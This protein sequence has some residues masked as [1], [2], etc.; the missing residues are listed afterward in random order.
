MHFGVAFF[1]AAAFALLCRRFPAL[2]RWSVPAGLLYGAAVWI[3]MY[4]VAIP[5]IPLVNSLYLTRFDRTMPKLRLRQLLIHLGCVGL[6]IALAAKRAARRSGEPRR[7]T[8]SRPVEA[9]GA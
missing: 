7:G 3:L 2:L 4:R 8:A 1:W 5:L 6:P 9:Q